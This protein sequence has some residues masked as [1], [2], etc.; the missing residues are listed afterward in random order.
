MEPKQEATNTQS[1]PP[2]STVDPISA[3]IADTLKQQAAQFEA[4]IS[5]LRDQMNL[6]GT[7]S[8][9]NP[10]PRRR[11]PLQLFA[12]KLPY[13]YKSTK[14]ALLVHIKVLWG[15]FKANDVPAPVNAKQVKAVVD[16]PHSANTV[17]QNNILTLKSLRSGVGGKVGCGMANLDKIYILYIPGSLA[18]V[19]LRVWGPDLDAAANSSCRITALNT[20]HYMNINPNHVNSMAEHI[21]AYNHY[22]HYWM[23]SK[24]KLEIRMPGRAGSESSKKVIQKLRKR[25]KNARVGFLKDHCAKYPPRYI[26]LCDNVLAHSDNEEEPGK[27]YLPIKTLGYQSKNDSKFMRRLDIEIAKAAQTSKKVIPRIERRLPK[28]PIPTAFPRAPKELPIDFY[29]P[30]WF[31]KL[32]SGQKGL[33]PDAT[34]VALLPDTSQSLF[35]FPQTHPDKS[36]SEKVF[37]TKY[38]NIYLQSYEMADQED[39]CQDSST[40]ESGNDEANKKMNVDEESDSDVYDEGDFG[41][42]YDDSDDEVVQGKGKDKA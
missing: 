26:L 1:K 27:N 7:S 23:E 41:D 30:S 4:I 5:G 16:D 8:R 28:E 14:E 33:I 18:K 24:Y 6:S 32:S 17:A 21:Q 12:D 19:G 37:N 29:K 35:P 3:L 38:L 36:L 20:F 13:D 25:L 40:A 39:E 9:R 34:Q 10:P 11:H 22:V 31:N 15:L 2:T 42:L